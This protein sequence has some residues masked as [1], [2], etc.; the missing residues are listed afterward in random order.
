MKFLEVL[1]CTARSGIPNSPYITVPCKPWSGE[2]ADADLSCCSLVRYSS[3]HDES[4]STDK[5]PLRSVQADR[6]YILIFKLSR[7]NGDHGGL[8]LMM[9]VDMDR[10]QYML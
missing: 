9:C 3:Y 4:Q 8:V 5:K 10:W 6:R 2:C 7:F 1:W